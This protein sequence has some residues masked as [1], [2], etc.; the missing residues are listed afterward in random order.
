MQAGTRT[1]RLHATDPATRRR[2][3][4]F[5]IIVAADMPNVRMA[6]DITLPLNRPVRKH[7]KYKNETMQPLRYT[8][9][10][11]D[12]ALVAVQSPELMLPPGDTRVIEL[13]FHAYPGTM[14]YNTE[15]YMFIASEDRAIQET[16]L[17]QLTYT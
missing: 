6:H 7:L 12:P 14:S 15:V 4:A 10:S 11:S 2:L 3:A 8:V 16:R 5:L 13:L 9:K 1:C 17:L